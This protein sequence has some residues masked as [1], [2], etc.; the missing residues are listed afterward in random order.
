MVEE[1]LHAARIRRRIG[2][3]VAG[4]AIKLQAPVDA[5]GLHLLFEIEALLGRDDR[6]VGADVDQHLALD[7]FRILRP[8]G[9]EAGMEADDRLEIAAGPPEL[10]RR[11]AAEAVADGSQSRRVDLLLRPQDVER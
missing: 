10:E 11:G 1:A 8:G 7:V 2:E 6:I 4:A 5:G 9:G 3:T